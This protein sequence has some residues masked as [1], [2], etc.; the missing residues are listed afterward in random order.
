VE[1]YFAEAPFEEAPTAAIV[2]DGSC[3]RQIEFVGVLRG[4]QEPDLAEAWVDFMLGRTFQEDIPLHMFVFPANEEATLP[5][6]FAR[7]AAVPEQPA[8]VAHA[9]IEA[10]REAWIEAWTEVVLR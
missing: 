4:A 9:A 8:T 5:D 1:V 3:F 2:A 10:N 6:V 7:F